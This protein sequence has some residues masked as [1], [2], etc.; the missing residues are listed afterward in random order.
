MIITHINP[1]LILKPKGINVSRTEPAAEVAKVQQRARTST[2][3]RSTAA[4]FL[5]AFIDFVCMILA[6]INSENKHLQVQHTHLKMPLL[7]AENNVWISV[8]ISFYNL[9]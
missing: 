4:I 1:C 3:M 5:M 6:A 7:M 8:R 9:T 2:Q